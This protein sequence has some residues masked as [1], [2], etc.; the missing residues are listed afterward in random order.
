[1]KAL[2]GIIKQVTRRK[3]IVG[4]GWLKQE[5]A[6]SVVPFDTRPIAGCTT[7]QLPSRVPDPMDSEIAINRRTRKR[8]GS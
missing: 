6:R 8:G 2:R 5:T 7:P 1:M 4:R 3:G